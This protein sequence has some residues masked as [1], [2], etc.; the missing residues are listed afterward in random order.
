[1]YRKG[2]TLIELLV[3]I[4]I[5]GILASIVLVSL[6]SA[7]TKAR[8]AKRLE[9]LT[10]IQ[11]A[12]EAYASSIGSYPVG[13][14]FSPWDNSSSFYAPWGCGTGTT[15][16]IWATM[17]AQGYITSFPDDPTN[18]ESAPP[19]FLGD[20]APSDQGYVYTS[21]GTN[22]ILGTN[23]ETK[24]GTASDCGNYQLTSSSQ[25]VCPL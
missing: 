20:N 21:N 11:T 25:Y 4:A 9:Q 6:N 10:Q 15:T 5:I 14:C 8:D 7:R 3:V 2:F 22:Y 23:L 13:T 19:N 16:P 17:V 1:M 18:K 24:T 12:L